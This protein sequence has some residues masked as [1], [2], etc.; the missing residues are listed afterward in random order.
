V[1][2]LEIEATGKF[3]SCIRG[4]PMQLISLSHAICTALC[5]AIDE[6]KSHKD[7][8][9]LCKKVRDDVLPM[10]EKFL[11][12]VIES[13][14]C[15]DKF[16]LQLQESAGASGL[17]FKDYRSTSVRLLTG[18]PFTLRSPYFSKTRPASQRR[19]KTKKRKTGT[20]CH[21]G[22]DHLG[23]I[24]RCSTLLGSIV[25]QAAL[26][27]PS[28][29]IAQKT[30]RSHAIDLNVKTI[31][32]I[33]MGMGKASMAQRG[34][35][36][37]SDKDGVEGKT[38]LVCVD[39]GRLRE[40]RPKRGRKPVNQ[41]RQGF[42]TDWK[43]PIQMVVQT[44]N[45]DGTI[46]K[47]DLP[48]YDATMGKI[49]AA[50]TL[51]ET[52]LRELKICKADRV[53]FCCDGARSYWNRI[54]TLAKKL[55]ITNHYEVIDYTHA[56]QNL[57]AIIDNLPDKIPDREKIIEKWKALLWQGDLN[58]LKKEISKYIGD[59]EK[60]KVAIAKFTSYFLRNRKRLQYTDFHNLKIPTGSGCVESAIRRVINLRLKSP[61]IFWKQE[62]AE[63][64]LFLRS[65]LLSGRWDIMITNIFNGIRSHT[66]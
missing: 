13:V 55:G 50:F 57:F 7:V 39:G 30:L 61:G 12:P 15:D 41:K 44:V 22:L 53:V 65:Q 28:F 46:C 47:K 32:R 35:V 16:L 26:L 3:I 34:K 54:G 37:I 45:N 31:R 38:V 6:F 40:R 42:H 43:E 56:K 48:L 59:K 10:V 60:R 18:T 17:Q 14:V 62:T 36:S 20:G 51:L 23:F 8:N 21:Y 58:T 2:V 24:N 9:R 11:L 29:D 33:V 64:M 52:Y 19:R 4:L 63:T 5:N 66:S 49:D 25:T 1:N 27:C